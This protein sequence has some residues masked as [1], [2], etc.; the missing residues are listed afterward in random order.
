MRQFVPI[1][2]GSPRF[3]TRE[4]G[5]LSV[6]EAWFPPLARLER[7]VHERPTVAIMLEGSFDVLFTRRTCECPAATLFTEPAEERHGNRIH[8]GGARVLVVQPDPSRTEL[9]RPC[10]GLLGSIH[11]ARDDRVT[12]L[13]WRL[14]RELQHPDAVS[15]LVTEGLSLELLAEAAR[16][17]D[18]RRSGHRPPAWLRRTHDLLRST[19]ASPLTVRDLAREAG[20]H[21]VHL[22]RSFR[23][24][25]GLS[26]GTYVRRLRLDRAALELART[27]R[28]I[29][30]IALDLGFADQSHLT[31]AF[32]RHTGL[33]PGRYRA[34]LGRRRPSWEDGPPD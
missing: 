31:R 23:A 5:G 24:H 3:T 27:G 4:V 33:T 2:M 30:E 8:K 7:H 34:R 28:A 10:A 20:V 6:T 12:A 19:L 14:S 25:Y 32:K 17:P 26:V 9:F 15:A 13:A 21:P 29:C 18:G 1:T 22:A 11:Q 16:L